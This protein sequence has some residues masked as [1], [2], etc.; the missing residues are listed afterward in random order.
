MDRLAPS[1]RTSSLNY[2]SRPFAAVT[3]WDAP[4]A[5]ATRRA[6][7]RAAPRARRANICARKFTPKPMEPNQIGPAITALKERS[8]ALRRY[9]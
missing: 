4:F 1:T 8:V 7:E 5:E 6:A 9:L 3:E 2:T